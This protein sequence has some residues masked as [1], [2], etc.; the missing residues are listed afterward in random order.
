MTNSNRQPNPRFTADLNTRLDR[1]TNATRSKVADLTGNSRIRSETDP[2]QVL[3]AI[4]DDWDGNTGQVLDQQGISRRL[5]DKVRHIRNDVAH[6][7]GQF[8]HSRAVCQE[9][10]DTIDALEAGISGA[11]VSGG[12][13]RPKRKQ[14]GAT[15]TQKRAV[16]QRSSVASGFS[17]VSLLNVIAT[18]T[19]IVGVLLAVAGV[20]GTVALD[21]GTPLQDLSQRIFIAGVVVAAAAFILNWLKKKWLD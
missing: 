2:Y 3:G 21:A 18:V 13:R 20:A 6:R 17:L 7:K 10:L 15:N 12:R 16:R 8:T 9:G 1:F 14:P 5:V 19:I 11:N 4:L